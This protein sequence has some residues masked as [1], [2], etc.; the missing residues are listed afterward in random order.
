[1]FVDIPTDLVPFVQSLISSGRCESETHVVAE[2]LQL[3]RQ[4]D[5]SRQQIRDAVVEGMHSGDSIP[6]SVVFGRLGRDSSPV[7][8]Q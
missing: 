4:T 5:E 3:L 8:S 7:A 1:M 6:E 2:A